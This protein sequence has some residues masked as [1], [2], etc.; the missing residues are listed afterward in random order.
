MELTKEQLQAS[1]Q[2]AN[3]VIQKLQYRVG[4]LNGAISLLEVER[5]TYFQYAQTADKKLE[6]SKVNAPESPEVSE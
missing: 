5:D 2:K 1:L 6:E 3:M 4:E